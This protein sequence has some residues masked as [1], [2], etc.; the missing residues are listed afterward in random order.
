MAS[1]RELIKR[2]QAEGIVGPLD[3]SPFNTPS[4][5]P[6]RPRALP[7]TPAE[8]LQSRFS[9]LDV[10]SERSSRLS[11]STPSREYFNS[12]SPS[13]SPSKKPDH[14]LGILSPA[15]PR[16]N[17]TP[18]KN[19][20]DTPQ[21][22][23]R[24]TIE[25]DLARLQNAK[26]VEKQKCVS[27]ISCIALSLIVGQDCSHDSKGSSGQATEGPLWDAATDSSPTSAIGG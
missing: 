3:L 7:R 6:V 17:G 8:S 12:S 16:Q 9:R 4:A 24:R 23:R 19:G 22:A 18:Q 20:P 11:P 21:S 15:R 26:P 13:S 25:G 2:L 5:S 10:N 1:Q 27:E 14:G